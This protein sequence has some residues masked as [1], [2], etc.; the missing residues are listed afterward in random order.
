MNYVQSLQNL[1]K[2]ISQTD[3]SEEVQSKIEP[4]RPSGF[5]PR[6]ARPASSQAQLA[7]TQASYSPDLIVS[8]TMKSLI[9]ARQ[10]FEKKMADL[11]KEA[12]VKTEQMRPRVR[13]FNITGDSEEAPTGSGFMTRPMSRR[14][15]IMN[16]TNFDDTNRPAGPAGS[17]V[18]LPEEQAVAQAIKDIE[19]S[20][21]NYSARGP[22]VETGMYA[23][24]RAM[25]AYQVMPSNLPQWSME[26]LGR[27]VS[28]A[29][30]MN[31]EEIQDTIFMHQMRKSYERYGTWEDAAS[32][33]FTGRPISRSEGAS[34]GYMEAPEYI[35]RFSEALNRY[36]GQ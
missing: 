27:E 9:Q 18:A 24:E 5:A 17:V 8:N 4:I 3:I 14:D 20:G 22:V 31:S 7:P 25:G 2:K 19:S 28:E 29:E 16:R 32:V 13:P 21:G 35:R 11:Q 33:W 34:D 30:F 12:Q 26:A 23:G 36:R 1:R 15:A 6:V 10:S